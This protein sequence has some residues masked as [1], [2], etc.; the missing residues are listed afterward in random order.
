[1]SMD[2]A[3]TFGQWVR[4]RR[5]ELG[6]TQEKIADV[7][8]YSPETI[9]KIE[10]GKRRPSHQVAEHLAD[11]LQIEPQE[12]RAFVLWARGL[13]TRDG[14]PR[15]ADSEQQSPDTAPPSAPGRPSFLP[16]LPT[17]LLGREREL[18]RIKG[19]LWR[20]T[21][22]LVTLLGPPGIGK[23]SLGIALAAAMQADFKDGLLYL[24]L[25]AVSDQALVPTTLAEALGLREEASRPLLETIQDALRDKQMLLIFD[26][27]EH[28]VA[29]ASLL[30]GLLAAAPQLKALV[31]SRSPLHL[32]GEKLVDVPPLDVPDLGNL[33]PTTDLERVGS[34]ALFVERARDVNVDFALTPENAP[35]VAAICMRLDGLP[36]AIELA[37]ARTRLLSLSGLLSRLERQLVVLTGGPRD[38]PP[39]HRTLRDSLESSY[40]LLSADEQQLFRRLGIF[41]GPFT[42]EAAEQVA[43]ATLDDLEAI[44]DQSL[45][46]LH[47]RAAQESEEAETRFTMLMSVR[48]Y[49]IEQL[50]AAGEFHDVALRH[51]GYF[52]DLALATEP[53]T[54]GPNQKLWLDRIEAAYGDI[55]AALDWTLKN[56]QT[57]ITLR[58]AGSVRYY[59]FI[60]G[61]RQ[62]GRRW[63]EQALAEG[64]D[65]PL[66]AR[67]AGLNALGDLMYRHGEREAAER[68]LSEAVDLSSELGEK[69]LLAR[70][71]LTLG[72]ILV[73]PGQV[74]RAVQCLIEC[75]AIYEELGDKVNTAKTLSSLAKIKS[76]QGDLAEAVAWLERALAIR[77]QL[78]VPTEIAI[79]MQSLGFLAL[80]Q[81]DYRRA[82]AYAEESAAIAGEIGNKENITYA[83]GVAGKAAL[84]LG[85]YDRA[86]T[87]FGK[88][89]SLFVELDAIPMVA[90]VFEEIAGVEMRLGHHT[91]AARLFG[92]AEALRDSVG[93]S[94]D[95]R[96]QAERDENIAFLRRALSEADYNAHWL[97]GQTMSLDK[98]ITYATGGE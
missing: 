6:L 93:A 26:N 10:S 90:F 78:G 84:E 19:L 95:L 67:V 51:A 36:L 68:Y 12:R 29:A 86:L 32:R 8:G 1:M 22:R 50:E 37:A 89:L 34:V 52:L 91:K 74:P 39:H 85:E 41:A 82:I 72:Q 7:T 48:E 4:Q 54:K 24:P 69:P 11:L 88:C 35:I 53:E 2:T 66:D 70:S 87:N 17:P 13:G 98:A 59:W 33:P 44:V 23:T 25:A 64:K 57:E 40:R 56:G 77:R 81:G 61:F 5:N 46:R 20:S 60:R 65:A 96:D 18:S 3:P 62:E 58:L 28:V 49:A 21:T 55:R 42:F 14:R 97:V 43:G 76:R 79:N 16:A 47:G 83:L 15:T 30:T 73:D 80:E 71:L 94:V 38:A 45:V 27:F 75:L 63:L 9:R 31:T 92:V